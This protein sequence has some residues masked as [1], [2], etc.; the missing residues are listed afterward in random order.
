MR[1]NIVLFCRLKFSHLIFKKIKKNCLFQE[2][3]VKLRPIIYLPGDYICR[4]DDI[5]REMYIVQSGFVQ[6]LG[7]QDGRTCLVTLS[8]GSVFGEIA[9]LG[10]G[11]MNRRTADVV[12]QGFSNLFTLLKE[13]LEET[14]KYYPDAKRILNAK[15]R[16]MMK[17]NE[18]RSV[19]EKEA[20]NIHS[21]NGAAA[22]DD[23]AVVSGGV[24]GVQEQQQATMD[25]NVDVLFQPRASKERRDPGLLEAVLRVMPADSLTQAYLRRGSRAGSS[26]SRGRAAASALDEVGRSSQRLKRQ[27]RGSQAELTSSQQQPDETPSASSSHTRQGDRLRYTLYCTMFMPRAKDTR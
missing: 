8:E 3:V 5:G 26:V 27:S 10:V 12:S 19:K 2:L 6:V 7:G 18:A 13:D 17:E 4:K 20:N 23:A 16:R 21:A 15:A 1:E 24:V 25:K 9:L 14:L 22:D 11:G